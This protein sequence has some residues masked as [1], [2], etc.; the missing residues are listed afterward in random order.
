MFGS[1]CPLQAAE[2]TC[3]PEL[4]G[5]WAGRQASRVVAASGLVAFDPSLW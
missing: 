5:Q 2:R 4:P 3:D 1:V